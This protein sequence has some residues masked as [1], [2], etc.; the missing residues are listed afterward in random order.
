MSLFSARHSKFWTRYVEIKSTSA[1]LYVLRSIQYSSYIYIL[2]PLLNSSL[3][4][5]CNASKVL[6]REKAARGSLWS[7]ASLFSKPEHTS[8]CPFVS[9]GPKKSRTPEIRATT[10]H[11]PA[12]LASSSPKRLAS[13]SAITK[14]ITHSRV[15]RSAWACA[16]INI[17]SLNNLLSF[18]LQLHRN[19]TE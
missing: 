17:L 15:V 10:R 3:L 14:K 19:S 12:I 16:G 5:T 18:H 2:L 6:L 8:T 11:V 13:V 7:C 9:S 4:L 1:S